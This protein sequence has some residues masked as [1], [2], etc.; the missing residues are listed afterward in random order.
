MTIITMKSFKSGQKFSLAVSWV[1][2][3]LH[4]ECDLPKETQYFDNWKLCQKEH[5]FD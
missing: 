3:Y 1:A 2:E 5:E 4:I